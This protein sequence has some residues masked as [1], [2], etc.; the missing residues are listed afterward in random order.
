MTRFSIGFALLAATACTQIPTNAPINVV[1]L[2]ARGASSVSYDRTAALPRSA[3]PLAT[4]APVAQTYAPAPV[5]QTYAPVSVPAPVAYAPTVAVPQ[6]S[7]YTPAVRVQ[8][9]PQPRAV[10]PAPAYVAAP[11]PAYIP[12]PAPQYTPAPT[13]IMAPDVAAAAPAAEARALTTRERVAALGEPEA[14]PQSQG[15]QFQIIEVAELTGEASSPVRNTPSTR[16]D[17]GGLRITSSE[18]FSI[19]TGT[20]GKPYYQGSTPPTL[21]Y[22]IPHIPQE[23]PLWCWAAAAQQ[24]I[25]WVN[26]GRAPAQCAIVALAHG[27]DRRHAPHPPAPRTA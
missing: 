27:L 20:T 17:A 12:A 2:E 22:H 10:V 7:R 16:S 5:V 23:E 25:G 21:E 15:R 8:A 24:A 19:S 4:R 1:P 18:P 26:N 6:S 3:P 13:P 14:L 11:A 9:A